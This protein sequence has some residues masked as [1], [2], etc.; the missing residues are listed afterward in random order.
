MEIIMYSK[1]KETVKSMSGEYIEGYFYT[2]S[3]A[4]VHS[5]AVRQDVPSL[6][7]RSGKINKYTELYYRKNKEAGSGNKKSVRCE[8]KSV[9]KCK[10]L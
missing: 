7:W 4:C 1:E 3:T 8:Y 2:H 5:C 10:L 6:G 9:Q